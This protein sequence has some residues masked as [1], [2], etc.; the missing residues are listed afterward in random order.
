MASYSR[1]TARG[2]R[3]LG[4]LKRVCRMPVAVLVAGIAGGC[5]ASQPT[6]PRDPGRLHLPSALGADF[7]TQQHIDARWQNRKGGFDAVLQKRA[8]TLKLLILTPF[9][10]RAFLLEQRGKNVRF[11]SFIPQQLPFPP[12]YILL[13]VQ[14]VFL[15]RGKA[16]RP[17]GRHMIVDGSEQRIETWRGGR[18]LRRRFRRTGSDDAIDIEYVGGMKGGTPPT[19]VRLDN[20]WFGYSLKIRS[21]AYRQIE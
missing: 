8:D 10:S 5:G 3:R 20:G 7:F 18:L 6:P 16:P 9:G 17:D 15:D 2:G 11:Q 13:D 19:E 21:L 4:G 1:S 12:R 14:R